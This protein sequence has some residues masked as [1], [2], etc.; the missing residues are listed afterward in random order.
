MAELGSSGTVADPPVPNPE[1]PAAGSATQQKPPPPPQT[2]NLDP[3]PKPETKPEE[4]KPAETKKR[5]SGHVE[6]LRNSA[7]FKIRSIIKDLRPLFI[8]VIHAPEFR[9]SKAANDIR[10]QMNTMIELTRQLRNEAP[11]AKPEKSEEVPAAGANKE[12]KQNKRENHVPQ[13]QNGKLPTAA[14]EKVPEAKGPA[15][16]FEE[17]FQGTYVIGGSPVDWN[18]LFYLGGTPVYCGETKASFRARQTAK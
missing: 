6:E 8:E 4:R 7:Y 10:K 3:T 16:Q 18:F 5:K 17:G 12:E 2:Q 15:K 9:E 13:P 14:K 11:A 1:A